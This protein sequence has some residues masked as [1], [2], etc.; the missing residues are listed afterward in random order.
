MLLGCHFGVEGGAPDGFV[1]GAILCL[2]CKFGE[3]VAAVEPREEHGVEEYIVVADR[4]FDCLNEVTGGE[5]SVGGV[6]DRSGV[7]F[8]DAREVP[9]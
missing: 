4:F 5:G 2:C 7:V 3:A 6:G 9:L 8:F 1:F